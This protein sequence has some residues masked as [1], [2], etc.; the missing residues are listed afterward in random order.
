MGM[1]IDGKWSEERIRNQDGR[2]VRPQSQFRGT[3]TADGSSGFKAEPGRY[4]LYVAYSCPWAHR[5]IIFRKLKGLEDVVSMAVAVPGARGEGWTFDDSFAGSTADEANGFRFLHQAYT[6]AQPGY[7]GTVTVPTLWDRK[8]GTIVNNESSEIIRMFNSAFD[9]VGAQ[10]GD[11]YPSALRGEIDRVNEF[12]YSHINNDVY[13]T[14]FASTQA[15]YEEAVEWVF[16]GLDTLEQRLSNHRY[17]VGDAITEA[18]WRLFVTLVRFDAVY[19]GLFKCNLRRIESY[20][21]LQNY[22]TELYQV[23]GVADTVRMDHIVRGYYSIPFANP[24]GI[25]PKVP[26]LDFLAPA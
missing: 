7:T 22:L 2:F 10:A 1:L 26:R 23:P 6:A 11:S 12:V 18:D 15:A 14:G 25:V 16:E 3:V 24:N 8:R 20:L 4:H 9:L 19:Y 21:H 17:L 13:R 5:T